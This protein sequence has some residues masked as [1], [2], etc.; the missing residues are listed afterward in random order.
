[1]TTSCIRL[2]AFTL[3][4]M[5]EPSDVE[6]CAFLEAP[7][8]ENKKVVEIHGCIVCARTLNVLAVYTPVVRLVDCAVT[9][10][11]GQRVPDKRQLLVTCDTHTAGEIEDCVSK[12]AVQEWYR[13]RR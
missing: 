11:G 5:I 7:T 8:S 4:Q 1:M 10:F 3:D 6:S 12:M 2:D 13:V 9:S